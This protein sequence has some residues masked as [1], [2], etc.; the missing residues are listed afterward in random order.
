MS[1]CNEHEE[2]IKACEE[3][4]EACL[5][6][7]AKDRAECI[8]RC[9]DCIDLCNL[10]A[11][12]E[13][14]KSPLAADARALCK[15][16]CEACAAACDADGDPECAACARACRACAAGCSLVRL[17]QYRRWRDLDRLL[18]QSK[19]PGPAKGSVPG[20]KTSQTQPRARGMGISSG[21]SAG[22]S[23]PQ[24]ARSGVS[25]WA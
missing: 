9:R 25:T 2:C 4:I 16:A 21:T 18:R 19:A 20:D 15:K 24:P 13:A 17:D 7:G 6:E 11:L 22:R 10:V 1:E 12:L 14:R 23:R 8:R 3:C 5:K